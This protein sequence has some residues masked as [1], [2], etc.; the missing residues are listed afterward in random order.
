MSRCNGQFKK[1]ERLS[2]T[3]SSIIK[4]RKKK[5]RD[6]SSSQ[7]VTKLTSPIMRTPSEFNF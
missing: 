7:L 6:T 5:A 4:E 2:K 3:N 1:K